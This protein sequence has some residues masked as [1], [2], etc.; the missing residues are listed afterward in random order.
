VG[1]FFIQSTVRRFW[2]I[3][4]PLFDFLTT[5]AGH[6]AAEAPVMLV[7]LCAIAMAS[8]IEIFFPAQK[9]SIQGRLRNLAHMLILKILG[10]GG[11]ALVLI[12]TPTMRFE[13]HEFHGIVWAFFVFVNLLVNDAVY[14]FYHRAQHTF[15]ALWALHELHHSDSELNATSSFRT[16]WLELPIQFLLI[17][18]PTML[19]FGDR[20][21]AHQNAVAL[22]SIGFLIFTHC[23]W[24]LRLGFLSMVFCGPQVHRIH[25]SALGEHRNKN[26]AQVFPFIDVVFGTHHRPLRHEFPDTGSRTLPS[27]APVLKSGLYRPFE[28]WIGLLK[29]RIQKQ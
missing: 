10:L 2:R 14:Y 11:L 21:P 9:Q 23:N 27:D 1:R 12:M 5:W 4:D 6:L 22:L 8:V 16:F 24:K 3:G 17:A 26:F 15:P 13:N 18:L 28:I 19:M 29:R 7:C 20:G 25:H